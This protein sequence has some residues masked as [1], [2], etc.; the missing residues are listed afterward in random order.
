MTVTTNQRYRLQVWVVAKAFAEAFAEAFTEVA[1]DIATDIAADIAAEVLTEVTTEV[2]V[3]ATAEIAVEVLAEAASGLGYC[4]QIQ[5]VVLVVQ[6]WQGLGETSQYLSRIKLVQT[7]L[8]W[9]EF[10]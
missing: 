5:L 4:L 2:T 1:A 10:I 7:E 3:E 6:A 8:V 9:T